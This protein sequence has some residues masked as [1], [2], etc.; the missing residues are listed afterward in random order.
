L[1][2]AWWPVFALWAAVALGALLIGPRPGIDAVRATGDRASGLR[3]AEQRNAQTQISELKQAALWGGPRAPIGVPGLPAADDQPALTPPDWRI[4]AV[5]AG[6]SDRFVTVQQGTQPAVE[7]RVGQ[8]LPD[9][10]TIRRIEAD[11]LY[12]VVRGN[13]RILRIGG[14]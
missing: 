2:Q 3:V 12:I 8:H 1:K 7:L 13:R 5:V 11:A 14:E 6:E 10:S 4:V 9:G